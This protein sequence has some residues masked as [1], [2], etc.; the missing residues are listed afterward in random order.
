MHN[1]TDQDIPLRLPHIHFLRLKQP[2][3]SE[4]L[5]LQPTMGSP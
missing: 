3:D 4:F 2:Q 1:E 5:M